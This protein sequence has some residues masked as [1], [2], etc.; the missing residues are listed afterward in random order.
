MGTVV[1]IP[2]QRTLL[3]NVSWESYER[4]LVDQ[5]DAPSPRFTFDRG[6]LEIMSPSSEHE[7]YKDALT[8]MVRMLADGLGMDIRSL[9]STTFNR[10]GLERGFEADACFYIQSVDR[11]EGKVHID[12]AVDPAP[13]LVIEIEITAPVLN[14]L[15]VYADFRVPEIWRYDGKRLVILHLQGNEYTEFSQSRA[16]PQAS[17]AELSRLV[18]RSMSLR[19]RE[20]L[21]E[22]RSWVQELQS[23]RS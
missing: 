19:S 3:Q 17:A 7:E 5:G 4:L 14:K 2:E 11:V 1:T 8:L 16:F 6:V 9:G 18:Q 20:W 21:R 13:D 15:P 23:S 10:K 12:P 22:L